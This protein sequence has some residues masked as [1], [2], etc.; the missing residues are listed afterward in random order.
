M[1]T[2]M[3]KMMLMSIVMFVASCGKFEMDVD[4]SDFTSMDQ[5]GGI[6]SLGTGTSSTEIKLNTELL[7][8]SEKVD[9]ISRETTRVEKELSHSKARFL[10]NGEIV[11]TIRNFKVVEKIY[12]VEISIPL[13]SNLGGK[14]EVTTEAT[15]KTEIPVL[16]NCENVY[17]SARL[18][19]VEFVEFI[20][21][22]E[23]KEPYSTVVYEFAITVLQNG[24]EVG[25][26]SFKKDFSWE[27]SPITFDANVEG[28]C[29][30]GSGD[31]N[32]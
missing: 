13:K 6:V 1:D 10:E 14:S 28:W 20:Q 24:Q 8:V 11:K 31:V 26:F 12:N 23:F 3:K 30:G 2:V 29:D 18:D 9:T 32:L 22:P 7:E 25:C 15:F 4:Y 16:N 21:D 19:S 5:N 17:V 27:N